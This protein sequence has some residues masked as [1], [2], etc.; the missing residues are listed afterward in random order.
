MVGSL[1]SRLFSERLKINHLSAVQVMGLGGIGNGLFEC[2]RT[3]DR[4]LSATAVAENVLIIATIQCYFFISNIST[5]QRA[6]EQR[7]CLW[8][9]TQCAAGMDWDRFWNLPGLKIFN[10]IPH[11]RLKTGHAFIGLS[12]AWIVVQE[13]LSR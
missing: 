4:N 7:F 6:H 11:A 5:I 2:G 1:L 8:K 3:A 10:R 9:H 12:G 13:I